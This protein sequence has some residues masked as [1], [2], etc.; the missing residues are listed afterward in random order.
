M[1]K[2][3]WTSLRS[4]S[5][6]EL[7][8]WDK[9]ESEHAAHSVDAIIR[10]FDLMQDDALDSDAIP[11][12]R[13]EHS[14]Q[15]ATRAFRAGQDEEYVVCALLHD[16][17]DMLCPYNHQDVAVAILRPFVSEK[18]LWIVQHHAL[19]QGYYF[20]H[21]VG[22]DR[23][24]RDRFKD[25]PW[26]DDVRDFCEAYDQAAFDPSYDTLPFEHFEPMLRRVLTKPNGADSN[27]QPASAMEAQMTT[28]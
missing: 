10:H 4:A 24:A 15:T 13:Y 11:V 6:E 12:S 23:H 21:H 19:F 3:Q 25:H 20:F 26:Y 17:G 9:A 7:L 18:N 2:A 14:L 22:G 8:A 1:T 27:D 5:K 28:S 16:I